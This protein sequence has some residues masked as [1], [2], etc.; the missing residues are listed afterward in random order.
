MRPSDAFIQKR[1]TLLFALL[2]VLSC[3]LGGCTQD[4]GVGPQQRIA[5]SCKQQ[6]GTRLDERT[7]ACIDC[8]H[9]VTSGLKLRYRAT[10][11]R[12]RSSCTLK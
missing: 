12:G 10:L 5:P 6:C 7:F 2:L 11:N 1:Q 8:C 4:Q 9:I 3:A